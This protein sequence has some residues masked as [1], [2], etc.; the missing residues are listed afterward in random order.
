MLEG[1]RPFVGAIAELS[2]AHQHR[3]PPALETQPP[4]VAAVVARAM[5]KNPGYRFASAGA[6]AG[7]LRVA[8]EN[9][10]MVLRRAMAL[11]ASRWP[12]MRRVSWECARVPIAIAAVAALVAAALFAWTRS[13]QL[14]MNIAALAAAHGWMTVT[15]ASNATF[16]LAIERLRTRPFENLDAAALAVDLRARLGLPADAGWLRTMFRLARFYFRCEMG[17]PVGTGDLAFL[18]GFLEGVPMSAISARTAA[19]AVGV[20]RSYRIVIITVLAGL[21]IVPFVEW[22]VLSAGLAPQFGEPGMQLAIF[23]AV[24]LTPLNAMRVNPVTSSALALLY[25]RARQALGEDVGLG[26]VLQG[27]L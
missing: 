20:K 17:A 24:L 4:K 25:F 7:C 5:A 8:A 3:P 14:A 11:Y 18:V 23:V 22:G 12:E 10:G 13:P 15:L 27:R 9:A 26:G 2:L 16:A 6:F 1:K 21:F 19:L